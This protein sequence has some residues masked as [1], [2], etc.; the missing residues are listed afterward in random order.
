MSAHTSD[1]FLD[2][3]LGGSVETEWERTCRESRERWK[4]SEAATAAVR[5]MSPEQREL[6]FAKS[7]HNPDTPPEERRFAEQMLAANGACDR[8]ELDR[9]LGQALRNIDAFTR[10]PVTWIA[11]EPESGTKH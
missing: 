4:R 6:A 1:H 2:Y 10:S 8:Q 5:A 9:Q 7:F 11:P 3:V